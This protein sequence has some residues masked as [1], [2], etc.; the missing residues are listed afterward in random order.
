MPIWRSTRMLTRFLDRASA[1]RRVIGPSNWPSEFCGAQPS[2]PSSAASL[3]SVAGITPFSSAAEYKN[4][5]KLEPGW[6]QAWVTWLKGWRAKS[7]P[8]TNARTRPVRASSAT[9][10]ACTSGHCVTA[11]AALEL[12]AFA[13]PLSP[14]AA[15]PGLAGGCQTRRMSPR[16]TRK[17][18]PALGDRPGSATRRPSPVICRA[19]PVAS[20]SR[21]A[22]GLAA[23]TMATRSCSSS[24]W[25]FRAWTA[26]RS[27]SAWPSGVLDSGGRSAWSSGPRQGW[28]AS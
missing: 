26:A 21:S 15:N 4:G 27:I 9:K 13:L 7:K 11:Q 5:L 17:S 8:P 20:C 12:A 24:S 16:A 14:G 10:A 23:S 22:R 28:R 3:T 19:S 6:R 25:S 18:L 1:W 2:A